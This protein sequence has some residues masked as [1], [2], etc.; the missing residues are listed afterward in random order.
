MSD[1]KHTA[2]E[3]LKELHS[4]AESAMYAWTKN[5][6][7]TEWRQ[8]V[9]SALRRLFGENCQ[10][11]KAFNSVSYSPRIFSTGKAD[12]VFHDS[13]IDGMKTARGIIRSAIQ[14]YEDYEQ[15]AGH[16]VEHTS[17][18]GDSAISRKVFVVHGHD[19]EMKDRSQ[20]SLSASTLKRSF[21]TNRQAAVTRSSRR[22][23]VMRTSAMQSYS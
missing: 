21:Y 2:Y 7:F 6:K 15:Q 12:S 1:P 19:N 20:D 16:D 22:L 23:N 18:D 13:F 3:R 4:E 14:E 9:Q 11:L 8:K 5:G 17:A 10:Q